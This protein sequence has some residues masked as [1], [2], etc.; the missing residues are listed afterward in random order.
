[1]EVSGFGVVSSDFFDPFSSYGLTS[2][3]LFMFIGQ[4]AFNAA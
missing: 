3:P 4:I 2:I 1:M